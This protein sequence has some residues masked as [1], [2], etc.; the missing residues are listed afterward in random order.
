MRKVLIVFALLLLPSALWAQNTLHVSSVTGQVQW[1][2]ASSHTFTALKVG[3]NQSVQPGDEI[4]TTDGSSVILMVPD[5]S[6]M[7]V[8]ENSRLIV[9]DFWSGSFKSMVNMMMGQVR[10]YIQRLGGRPN[11]YSVRTPTA[12]IAVRGTVFDVNVDPEQIVVVRCLEG[13]VTVENNDGREV[14]LDEGFKTLVRPGEVPHKPVRNEDELIKDRLIAV[15]KKSPSDTDAN[16][17]PSLDIL[18]N[19]SDRRNRPSD[20][21]FG[22]NSRSVDNPQRAKPTLTFP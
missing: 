11:P 20:P 2:A 4:R 1:R 3:A 19:D 13:R 14:V 10:F 21:Q 22:S 8:S 18:R 6:Y 12:L 9:E 7:V 17:N 16:G 5:G 15:R